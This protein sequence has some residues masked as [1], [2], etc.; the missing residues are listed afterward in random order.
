MKN[1]IEGEMPAGARVL[2]VEDLISTG[3]SSL[4]AVDAVRAEGGVVIGTLAIF[5]YGFPDATEAFAKADCRLETLSNYGVLIET[6]LAE[7]YIKAEEVDLL[8]RWRE[9]PK[10]WGV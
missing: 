4:Q 8:K 2:V 10:T 7:G 3:M 5:T 6:A 9:S 1:L